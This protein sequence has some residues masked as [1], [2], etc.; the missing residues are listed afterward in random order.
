MSPAGS[1]D[2]DQSQ[3]PGQALIG[4]FTAPVRS[5]L[6]TETGSAGLLLVATGIALAWANSP[7]SGSYVSLWGTEASV[8]I[9]ARGLTMDLA[10]WVNDGLMVIFFF[11][12]GL[13]L[14]HEISSGELRQRRRLV[15]PA[16]CAIGGLLIPALLYLAVNP[17]GEA[18]NGW[19]VVIGTDTA[20]LLGALALV[21]PRVSS[22][23]RVFLLTMTIVDDLIA[24]AVIGAV[25]S[26][27]INY[28]AL[29]I[30]VVALGGIALLG[31][32]GVWQNIIYAAMLFVAWLA[33]L[34]SGLHPSIAG[35]VAGLLVVSHAPR[36]EALDRASRLFKAFR[37]SPMPN[38]ASVAKRGLQRAM[39]VNER[40][41]E[42]LH[43]WTSYAIVPVFA[44]ANAGVDLRGG[45]L[46]DALSSP[47]TWGVVFG[48]V[49]GKPIGIAIA[50]FAGVSLKMAPLP[51]GVGPGQVVGGGALSG[52]GFSVSLLIVS[53]AFTTS[54]M[55]D[56][57]TVGVLLACAISVG[58]G[59]ISFRLAARLLGEGT[60]S[61]PMWLDPPVDIVHDH[62][63][64]PKN[65]PLTL[66]EYGD[67]E[68]PFCGA[69][70]NVVR[71]LRERFGN[72]LR[73]VFRHLPLEDI[74]PHAVMAA[75]AAEAAGAQGR[76]WLMHDMLFE[77]HDELELEDLLGYAAK[78]ELDV[79][80]FARAMNEEQNA[81][82]VREDVASAEA[83]GARR[84]P[85]F[86]IGNRRH[87]GPHDTETLA[88]ELLALGNSSGSYSAIEEAS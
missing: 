39:P 7:W 57:A 25:Y 15:I 55:V 20:F 73:Y 86:F 2:A 66:V 12:V 17:S 48:L 41:Q 5:F 58:T 67:F 85:T 45:L 43:P 75:E 71:E 61:L 28:V 14:R 30:A 50:A 82:T 34:Q 9:G 33:T 42:T 88:R 22:Q 8:R 70:T 81:E 63:R 3:A 74:H 56:E 78:L 21:G 64:G 29:A 84:T 53:L 27:S 4:Q 18:A 38:A 31:K 77:H 40:L 76:F 62:I 35:M 83:S 32:L 37:Q 79:E 52:L 65:A 59:W 68:C 72:Q 46:G 6:A 23:L 1:D 69:A 16:L 13:E 87:I 54:E 24:V 11:V 49:V 44:L 47:V 60:S 19:G 10:H 51:R 36:R 80:Q 26:E